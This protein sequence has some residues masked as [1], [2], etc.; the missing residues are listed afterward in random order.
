MQEHWGRV[1]KKAYTGIR[2]SRVWQWQVPAP[3]LDQHSDKPIGSAETELSLQLSLECPQLTF[4]FS[5][6]EGTPV[7]CQFVFHRSNKVKIQEKPCS[8]REKFWIRNSICKGPEAG[9]SLMCSHSSARAGRYKA[10]RSHFVSYAFRLQTSLHGL[11]SQCA[12]Y[13]DLPFQEAASCVLSG[14]WAFGRS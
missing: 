12:G 6:D 7:T 4:T 9:M 11:S 14:P 2:N 8:G 3:K 5:H 1:L 10:T 13:S